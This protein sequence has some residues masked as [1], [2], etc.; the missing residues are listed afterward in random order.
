MTRVVLSFDDTSTL[1]AARSGAP[2]SR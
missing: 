1:L 2:M